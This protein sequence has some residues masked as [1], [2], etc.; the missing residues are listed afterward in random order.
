MWSQRTATIVVTAIGLALLYWQLPRV[1]RALRPGKARSMNAG[2][3]LPSPELEHLSTKARNGDGEAAMKVFDHYAFALNQY[4]KAIP[5]LKI[6]SSA[7]HPRAAGFMDGYRRKAEEG[8]APD[9]SRLAPKGISDP[10][11]ERSP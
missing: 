10:T 9:G 1:V 2:M 7:G 6:A 11:P 4:D 8:M 5:F 3:F